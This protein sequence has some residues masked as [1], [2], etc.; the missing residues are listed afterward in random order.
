MRQMIVITMKRSLN[1]IV[2]YLKE[3][4]NPL[5]LRMHL[6]DMCKLSS[7]NLGDFE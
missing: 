3:K 5:V 6:K 4:I 7:N 1:N 2:T